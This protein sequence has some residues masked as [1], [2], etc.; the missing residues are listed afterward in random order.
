VD[1]ALAADS[2]APSDASNEGLGME[3]T[4]VPSFDYFRRIWML[5]WFWYSLVQN[6]LHTRYRHSFLGVGWS[7]ARPL[8]LTLVFCIVFGQLFRIPIEDYAPFVLVGLTLWQFL[9]EN[10]MSGCRT[11]NAGASYIR[12]QSVPLAIFPLRT[13]LGAAFHTGAALLLGLVVTWY[14]KGFGN[15]SVLPIILP[16]MVLLFMLGWSLAIL[17]G[18][19]QTHFPDTCYILELGL[20]FL[21]YLTPIIYRPGTLQLRW[22]VDCNPLW[23]VLELVRQPILYGQLPPLYNVVVSLAFVGVLATL[24]IVCLRRLE[25]TLVFWI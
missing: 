12:Q 21:F 16:S 23:S 1:S 17:C 14:F 11:F 24:A 25:R 5:R 22:V 18:L 3:A 19:A 6:D 15:L 8:G 10:I 2:R 20:Q 7:L 9:V 13:A 4:A